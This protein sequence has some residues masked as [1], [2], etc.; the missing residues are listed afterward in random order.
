M[1]RNDSKFVEG[2]D[3]SPCLQPPER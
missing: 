1:M 3:P 2:S